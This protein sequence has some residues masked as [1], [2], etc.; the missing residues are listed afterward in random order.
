MAAVRA[1]LELRL[2]SLEL[3]LHQVERLQRKFAMIHS[4]LAQQQSHGGAKAE[5]D[6]PKMGGGG[7][8]QQGLGRGSEEN[9]LNLSRSSMPGGAGN[10][11]VRAPGGRVLHPLNG[12]F[13]LATTGCH[14]PKI[15]GWLPGCYR[16]TVSPVRC[17]VPAVLCLQASQELGKATGKMGSMDLGK[18]GAGRAVLSSMR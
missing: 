18:G 11:K 6:T 10:V 7:G 1:A 3:E 12:C 17:A 9:P 8:G 14:L 13:C 5:A 16:L 2:K 4:T 15:A